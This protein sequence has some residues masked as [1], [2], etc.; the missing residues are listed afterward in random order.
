MLMRKVISIITAVVLCLMIHTKADAQI[1]AGAGLAYGLDIEKIG[2]QVG[3]TYGISDEMRVG[4]DIIYWFGDN[5][6]N[7][8]GMGLEERISTTFLEVNAN[9]NYIF[10]SENDLKLYG[11]GTLGI[12]Y[13]SFS[14]ELWISGT[15][16]AQDSFSDS[17]TEAAFGLGVGAEYSLGNLLIY[18]EP[19][20]FLSGFDQFA[21]SAGVR[22]PI[23]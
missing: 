16:H 8:L 17:D 14:D 7:D 12:H 18:A 11:I 19:R 10:Y 1:N 21:L 13:F 23:R 22:I 9:F 5:E 2:I 4:L 6:T 20:V 15:S 3:G